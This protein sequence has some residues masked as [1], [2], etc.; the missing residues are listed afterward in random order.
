MSSQLHDI[1]QKTWRFGDFQNDSHHGRH[2]RFY[3]KLTFVLY[4]RNT[5]HYYFFFWIE[6]LRGKTSPWSPDIMATR[7]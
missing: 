3:L 1:Y 4:P 7:F 6:N 2:L 5:F